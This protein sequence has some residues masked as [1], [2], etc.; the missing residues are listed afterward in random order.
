M[1]P[2]DAKSGFACYITNL[3]NYYKG[4]HVYEELAEPQRVVPL[5]EMKTVDNVGKDM[6]KQGVYFQMDCP[7]CGSGCT[8]NN[9]SGMWECSTCG[10]HD[11][12]FMYDEH[13][14]KKGA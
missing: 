10:W 5:K 14:H 11:F 1:I 4:N 9:A 7:E 13:G 6:L 12:G 2:E 8:R 3:S